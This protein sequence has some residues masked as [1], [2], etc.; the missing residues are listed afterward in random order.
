MSKKKKNKKITIIVLVFLLV[1][2]LLSFCFILKK[3]AMEKGKI[4]TLNSNGDL[5][6]KYYSPAIGD[7]TR[8]TAGSWS[9]WKSGII[10]LNC[11]TA[12]PTDKTSGISY[13]RAQVETSTRCYQY[14]VYSIPCYRTQNYT[15]TCSTANDV[16]IA[17]VP[18]SLKMAQN[19]TSGTIAA[20]V[21]VNGKVDTIYSNSVNL[22]ASGVRLN[23]TGITGVVS[24][25]TTGGTVTASV[26]VNGKTYSATLNVSVCNTSWV[27]GGQTREFDSVWGKFSAQQSGK[28]IYMSGCQYISATKKYV[29]LGNQWYS[30]CG[31]GGG[32]SVEYGCFANKPE[33]DNPTDFAH[34]KDSTH[35]FKVADSYC[36]EKPTEVKECEDNKLKEGSNSKS[37]EYCSGE[38]EMEITDTICDSENDYYK[39]ESKGKFIADFDM[40]RYFTSGTLTF[41]SG[42]SFPFDIKVTSTKRAKGTFNTSNWT[43]DYNK[44]K[45]KWQ[46]AKNDLPKAES[47]LSSARAVLS[48]AERT[49][50]NTPATVSCNPKTNAETGEVTYET[51]TN[52]AYTSA[53]NDV[54]SAQSN[55]NYQKRRV[56]ND[57]STI[58]WEEGVM[59]QL[60]GIVNY[61]QTNYVDMEYV[62]KNEPK[63]TLSFDY[64]SKGV[65]KNKTVTPYIKNTD[66]SN[67][68][69]IV[70]KKD[71]V[72]SFTTYD[73]KKLETYNFDYNNEDSKRIQYMIAPTETLD[74]KNGE[75][76]GSGTSLTVDGGNR[77]YT[78]E[79]EV[80][81][82]TYDISI[83]VD[84]LGNNKLSKILNDKCKLNIYK[85]KLSYRI[86]DV[87][88]PFV[89][90]TY[91]KGINWLN[92]IYDY[93]KVIK[94]GSGQ[95][96]FNLS[97]NDI[98]TIK[99]SNTK[100]KY[101]GTCY[102]DSNMWDAASR[103]ICGTV[104][105]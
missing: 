68:G 63:I 66:K 59:D 81:A 80:D 36:Q 20:I 37:A 8:W 3:Y 55:V 13:C 52:P 44:S 35:Q 10:P 25:D 46:D 104:G 92:S 103:I 47:A 70:R 11:S 29:C 43:D 82:G 30:K 6:S 41:K 16:R 99:N 96:T 98:V 39:V 100:D 28:N 85:T 60:A 9:S 67:D 34:V 12:E 1:I 4:S 33:G 56:E 90:S 93:T 23:K 95:Y 45:K 24:T 86:V 51:C 32:N 50:A 79:R 57:K 7:C 65:S 84:E 76:A 83:I 22:T 42:V 97:S 91:P 88:N 48:S 71:K 27:Q 5:V 105:K 40:D 77:I 18:S 73:S 64:K 15:R 78:N 72:L 58:A 62:D 94:N 53:L 26:S 87:N 69:G 61:Y 54:T 102:L 17:I 74:F 101:L 31:G 19:D 89:N 49:L 14:G 21:Y 38:T 75:L 2:C